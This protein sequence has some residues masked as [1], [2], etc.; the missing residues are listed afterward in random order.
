[1]S[2]SDASGFPFALL[3]FVA[4][5]GMIAT[6]LG[7]LLGVQFVPGSSANETLIEPILR[8]MK[9]APASLLTSPRRMMLA[10]LPVTD[11]AVDELAD[12]IGDAGAD[13]LAERLECPV[14]DDVK[15]LALTLGE[16]ALMPTALEDP[17]PELAELRAV[18][19]ADHQWR[20]TEGID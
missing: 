1:M 12:L 14:V 16:S 19:L 15:L 9:P 11:D 3:D 4:R 20:R 2:G 5:T 13:D 7:R 17:P 6:G 10:G 8:G 18:L